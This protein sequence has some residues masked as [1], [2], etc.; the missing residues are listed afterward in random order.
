MRNIEHI[1][2][3][4][5]LSVLAFPAM[6]GQTE[7]SLPAGVKK[8]IPENINEVIPETILEDLPESMPSTEPEVLLQKDPLEMQVEGELSYI[9]GGIGQDEAT[10]MRQ[11]AKNYPL[12]VVFAQKTE[13]E[14]GYIAM[15]KLQISDVKGN[16]LLDFFSDGPIFLANLPNGKY[17]INAEYNNILRSSRVTISNKKHQR[18]VFLW[19]M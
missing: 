16:I 1:I 18:V 9:S 7:A 12:E 13:T 15:V 17:L 2:V 4:L 3:A 8:A 5:M 14:E 10:E 6:P 19:P 11:M